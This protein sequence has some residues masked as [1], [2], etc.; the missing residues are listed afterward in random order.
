VIVSYRVKDAFFDRGPVI[1]A[2]DKATLRVMRR[3]GAAVRLRA[4]RSLRRRKRVSAPGSPPSVHSRDP[5]A[6]LRNILF[7]YDSAAHRTIVGPV[8]L[9]QVNDTA[10]RGRVTLPELHEYGGQLAIREWR[11]KQVAHLEE[12][13]GWKN[14]PTTAKFD[15]RWKRED[16]RWQNR[17]KARGRHSLFDLGV[18]RR[19]RM[20][21]YPARPFMRPALEKEMPRFPNLF[22][23]ALRAA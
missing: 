17:A 20:A 7:A 21:T 8:G 22:H 5:V 4:R 19:I 6:T 9:N 2:L 13:A 18:E 10:S 23:R 1:T 12:W 3:A 14:F 15:R 16:R 11:F